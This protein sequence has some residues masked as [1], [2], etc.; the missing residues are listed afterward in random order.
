MS[1]SLD[2][3]IDHNDSAQWGG[4]A[5]RRKLIGS[6]ACAMGTTGGVVVEPPQ[7][8]ARDRWFLPSC[9]NVHAHLSELSADGGRACEL[10]YHILGNPSSEV[11]FYVAGRTLAD[12]HVSLP[13]ALAATLDELYEPRSPLTRDALARL[14]LDAE[15]AYMR[16]QP[17]NSCGTLSLEPLYSD[18][19]GPAV[20]LRDHLQPVQRDAYAKDLDR[21]AIDFGKIRVG[22]RSA[23]RV[24]RIDACLKRVQADLRTLRISSCPME[25]WQH[26]GVRQHEV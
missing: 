22:L 7:H 10:Y 11:T 20:Y 16:Y 17:S 26:E 23:T 6:L 12:P 9:G 24:Q 14:F 1:R 3:M 8:W 15:Q 13:S 21:L 19:P 18:G 25:G 4:S 2:Y 5:Y